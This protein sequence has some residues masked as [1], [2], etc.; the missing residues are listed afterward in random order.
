[1]RKAFHAAGRSGSPDPQGRRE[2]RRIAGLLLLLSVVSDPRRLHAEGT[3]TATRARL[4]DSFS[5]LQ[6]NRPEG[7]W[8][9]HVVRIRRA[10]AALKLHTVLG[11]GNH[12]GLGT[13]SSQMT[14]FPKSQGRP[15]A[16]VNG[17]YFVRDGQFVGD[18]EGLCIVE[19]RL[20][21]TP[22]QKSCFWVAPD[23]GFHCTNVISLLSITWPDGTKTPADLNEERKD[24]PVIYTPDFGP[25][26]RHQTGRE[27]VLQPIEEVHASLAPGETR[28]FRVIEVRQGGGLPLTSSN[29]VVALPEVAE[30]DLGT[31]S[32]GSIATI[33]T[34][35]LP[36]LQG[37]RTAVGG[38]PALVHG[39]QATQLEA[40]EVRH[41]RTA[42]GWNAEDFFLVQV[43]GRQPSISVGMSFA[44]LTRYFLELGCT[45]ALNLDGGGS[46]TLWVQGQVANNPSEGSERPMANA[47]VIALEPK[48]AAK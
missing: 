17:D 13:L 25:E 9:I 43:D 30:K 20:V 38:G 22:S 14:A 12:L 29:L 47:L 3:P 40:G 21:S 34:T 46:S 7:P 15:I 31:L 23:G 5:Y 42:I 45:E 10:R 36:S 2:L 26:T 28:K 1:M 19:G 48:P 18:P 33:D 27:V 11:G 8:S 41:P 37:V 4:S 32:P 44:E 24:R 6:E 39:G 35:S 16:A